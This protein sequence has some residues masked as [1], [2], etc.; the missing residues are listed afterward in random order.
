MSYQQVVIGCQTGTKWTE[1][2]STSTPDPCP[3]GQKMTEITMT[4]LTQSDLAINDQPFDSALAAQF[5]GFAFASTIFL[6]ITSLCIGEVI[7]LVRS[8]R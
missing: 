3:S 8:S 4:V 7:S 2:T 5:F 6:W 1:P